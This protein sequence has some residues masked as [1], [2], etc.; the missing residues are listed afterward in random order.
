[1]P[2]RLLFE[3]NKMD[4]YLKTAHYFGEEVLTLILAYLKYTVRDQAELS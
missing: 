2:P 4:G 3:R 1:V